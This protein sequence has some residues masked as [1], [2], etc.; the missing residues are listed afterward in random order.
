MV[1]DRVGTMT[2]IILLV[3]YNVPE[4]TSL[5]FWIMMDITSHW[6]RTAR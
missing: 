5:I 1:T 2:F 6:Y 3:Q 4:T